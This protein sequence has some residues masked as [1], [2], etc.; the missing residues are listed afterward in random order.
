MSATRRTVLLLLLLLLLLLHLPLLL[1]YLPVEFQATS[2][3]SGRPAL[4]VP[5]DG[6]SALG[7]RYAGIPARAQKEIEDVATDGAHTRREGHQG[8]PQGGVLAPVLV[9]PV[10]QEGRHQPRGRGCSD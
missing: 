4:G 6:V 10:R 2:A 1:L 9:G 7:V 5:V 8:F 3:I